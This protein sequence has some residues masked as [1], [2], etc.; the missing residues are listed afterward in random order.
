MLARLKRS[1]RYPREA[2][3]RSCRPLRR[4]A[5]T[6][7][8]PTSRARDADS[9]GR[10]A[11]DLRVRPGFPARSRCRQ[12]WPRRFESSVRAGC[13]SLDGRR[14]SSSP[15]GEVLVPLRHRR[16]PS[17]KGK[18]APA[19]KRVCGPTLVRRPCANG[20]PLERTSNALRRKKRGTGARRAVVTTLE[21]PRAHPRPR[22]PRVIQARDLHHVSAVR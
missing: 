2:D 8:A 19:S 3:Q 13:S 1:Q 20:T 15:Y 16:P 5:T 7:V 14:G 22:V 6:K 18:R 12:G 10:R 9:R 4:P 17:E 21:A 11:R